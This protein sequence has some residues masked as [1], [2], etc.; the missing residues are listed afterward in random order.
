MAFDS[1][2]R[3]EGQLCKI[4]SVAAEV[5]F[6][7]SPARGLIAVLRNPVSVAPTAP[8]AARGG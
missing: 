8:K 5:F 1:T 4:E 6:A 7:S 2:I 3:P